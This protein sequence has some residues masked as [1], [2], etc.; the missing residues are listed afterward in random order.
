MFTAIIVV[1]TRVVIG[2]RTMMIIVVIIVA[3]MTV[4]VYDLVI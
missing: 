3:T 2:M 4:L 1:L